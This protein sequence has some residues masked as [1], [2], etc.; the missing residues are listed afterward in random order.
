MRKVAVE[1]HAADVLTGEHER[2]QGKIQ[3]TDKKRPGVGRRKFEQECRD[4][5]LS[6]EEN[7]PGEGHPACVRFHFRRQRAMHLAGNPGDERFFPAQQRM[8]EKPQQ[9]QINRGMREPVGRGETPTRLTVQQKGRH[10]RGQQ[11]K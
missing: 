5:D 2:Q 6:G 9:E 11:E 10:A 8:P 3:Q 4:N 1:S 7:T